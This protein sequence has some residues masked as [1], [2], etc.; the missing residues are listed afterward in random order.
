MT[1]QHVIGNNF[2]NDFLLIVIIVLLVLICIC[3]YMKYNG[4]KIISDINQ[5][6][7]FVQN[8]KDKNKAADLLAITVDRLELLI[9]HLNT[10]YPKLELV[11]RLTQKYKSENIRETYINSDYTSFTEDKGKQVNVC[12]RSKKTKERKLHDINTIMFV[13]IHELGHI[14]SIS[15]HHTDEFLETFK[16]LLK[17]SIKIGI[18]KYVDYNKYP[19][20]YCGIDI[21]SNPL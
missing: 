16:F 8:L 18:Y 7:Y 3:L 15:L 17:E 10:N 20:E 21:N 13:F 5:K 11:Q 19:V 9:R 1:K 14:A 2:K 12:L 6:S 4:I